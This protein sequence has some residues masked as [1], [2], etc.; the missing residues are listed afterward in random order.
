VVSFLV[1]PIMNV[2]HGRGQPAAAPVP[3]SLTEPAAE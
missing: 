1:P 2:E 3:G